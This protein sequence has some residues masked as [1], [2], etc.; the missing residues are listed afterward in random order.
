MSCHT[1]DQTSC[2]THRH[3]DTSDL[4]LLSRSQIHR[5]S[6]ACTFQS[7]VCEPPD[8]QLPR[9]R[10]LGTLRWCSQLVSE[11]AQERVVVDRQTTVLVVSC[12]TAGRLP[13]ISSLHFL[14]S[15]ET[16]H[17]IDAGSTMACFG[18]SVMPLSPKVSAVLLT[19]FADDLADF[20]PQN[21]LP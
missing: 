17:P 5:T 13:L 20:S 7:Y 8:L 11:W 14:Q 1:W 6:Q 9:Q 19:I 15:S 10:D 18:L 4:S 3:A 21:F 16:A 2:R 12:A